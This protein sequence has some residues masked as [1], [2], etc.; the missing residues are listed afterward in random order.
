MKV[1]LTAGLTIALCVA[2]LVVAA[3]LSPLAPPATIALVTSTPAAECYPHALAWTSGP[4][5]IRS[6][7]SA[8]SPK[9][10]V[11]RS[12]ERFQVHESLQGEAY[13]WLRV[14]AGLWL[15]KTGLVSVNRS[16]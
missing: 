13:C 10:R 2:I 9:Q 8:T 1:L 16:M 15:A 11:T 4:M 5:N 6:G 3:L 14:D 7:P 12:G